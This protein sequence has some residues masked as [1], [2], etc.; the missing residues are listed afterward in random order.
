MIYCHRRLTTNNNTLSV[1]VARSHA[2]F[3]LKLVSLLILVF[4]VQT[5]VT[6]PALLLQTVLAAAVLQIRTKVEPACAGVYCHC[7]KDWIGHCPTD[8]ATRYR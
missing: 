4:A 1:S 2:S 6:P 7:D 8:A 3:L 5:A